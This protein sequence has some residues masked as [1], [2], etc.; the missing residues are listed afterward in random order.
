MKK[1]LFVL[2]LLFTVLFL[3]CESGVK[4]E[5]GLITVDVTKSYP[6]KELILQDL[7]DIEYLPLET[8]DKFVTAGDVVYFGDD[9]MWIGD[10][11]SFD[12]ELLDREKTNIRKI[13]QKR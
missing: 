8:S 5:N 12:L 11:R 7:F 9:L 1:Y 4:T 2:W 3:R 10:Y 6:K 13:N